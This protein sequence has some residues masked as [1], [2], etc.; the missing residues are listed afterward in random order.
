MSCVLRVWGKELDIHRLLTAITMTPS[1]VF[2]KGEPRSGSALLWANSGANFEVSSADFSR[3]SEQ[4]SDALQFLTENR[5]N[6]LNIRDFPGVEGASI[7]FA[8]VIDPERFPCSFKFSKE[9]L[10]SAGTLGVSL[11]LS[12]YPD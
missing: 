3:L 10:V 2:Q 6:L 7:D 12:I 1:A 9:L 5:E 4:E 11:E 8:A